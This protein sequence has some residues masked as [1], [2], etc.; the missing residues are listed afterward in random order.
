MPYQRT[1]PPSRVSGVAISEHG[2]DEVATPLTRDGGTVLWYGIATPDDRVAVSPYDVY[3]REI[4]I[5]GSYAQVTSVRHAVR[6]LQTGRMLTAGLITHVFPL[7]DYGVCSG[8]CVASGRASRRSS[9][10]G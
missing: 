7:A 1:V 2:R 5:K 6:A 8:Q 10:R 9:T 4:T 3:R